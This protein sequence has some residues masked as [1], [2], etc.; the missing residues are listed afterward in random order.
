MIAASA[1]AQR[2]MS[3][4]PVVGGRV[5]TISAPCNFA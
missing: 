2:R 3:F 4:L 1:R 5:L